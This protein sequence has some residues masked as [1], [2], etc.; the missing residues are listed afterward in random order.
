[1]L[2]FILF[3]KLALKKYYV[4]HKNDTRF[5]PV[6]YKTYN[7]LRFVSWVKQLLRQAVY[8]YYI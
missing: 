6:L 1:M 7:T 5:R 8:K 4:I 2:N 3:T